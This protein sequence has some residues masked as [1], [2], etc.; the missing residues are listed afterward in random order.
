MSQTSESSLL[1]VAASND[2]SGNYMAFYCIYWFMN[3]N[4]IQ[5]TMLPQAGYILPQSGLSIVSPMSSGTTAYGHQSLYPRPLYFPLSLTGYSDPH[6]NEMNFGS[7][8][9]QSSLSSSADVLEKDYQIV[10]YEELEKLL[11]E[12]KPSGRVELGLLPN[13]C[14]YAPKTASRENYLLFASKYSYILY[15]THHYFSRENLCRDQTFLNMLVDRLILPI[16]KL[17]KAPRL[18]A[19]NTTHEEVEQAL[20]GSKI[21]C[22]EDMNA[23]MRGVRRID[24]YPGLSTNSDTSTNTRPDNA[25]STF[26]ASQNL[27]SLIGSFTLQPPYV[28]DQRITT[29]PQS[30]VVMRTA[31]PDKFRS[32]GVMRSSHMNSEISKD[33][34]QTSTLI[35]TPVTTSVYVVPTS[36]QMSIPLLLPLCDIDNLGNVQIEYTNTAG[37]SIPSCRNTAPWIFQQSPKQYNAYPRV[38]HVIVPQPANQPSSTDYSKNQPLGWDLHQRPIVPTTNNAHSGVLPIRHQTHL[39]NYFIRQ[40]V[41]ASEPYSASFSIAQTSNVNQ[42][43]N[44]AV[45]AALASINTNTSNINSNQYAHQPQYFSNQLLSNSSNISPIGVNQQRPSNALLGHLQAVAAMSAVAQHSSTAPCFHNPVS[46]THPFHMST[47]VPL[48]VYY[49]APQ[50]SLQSP[51]PRNCLQRLHQNSVYP[52]Q[53]Y[54]YQTIQNPTNSESSDGLKLDSRCGLTVPNLPQHTSNLIY[55]V[56]LQPPVHLQHKLPTAVNATGSQIHNSGQPTRGVINSVG[57]TPVPINLT[58]INTNVSTSVVSNT[59]PKE[60]SMSSTFSDAKANFNKNPQ[61]NNMILYIAR[62]FI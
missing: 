61:E 5:H 2:C 12:P 34:L 46:Q 18:A 39:P 15:F 22:I 10:T 47:P 27:T 3:Q 41:S 7:S 13:G 51:V 8:A 32:D 11:P 48:P 50:L 52:M 56:L 43:F 17:I 30:V 23:G 36:H 54:S 25:L 21:V 45:A 14:A 35:Q 55:P 60:M 58:V 19:L 16:E 20:L 4:R 62:N 31:G 59:M 37:P 57:L 24:G 33:V 53:S 40:T 1:A 42:P 28:P 49:A 38:A 29:S 6:A 9:V 44:L 26:D